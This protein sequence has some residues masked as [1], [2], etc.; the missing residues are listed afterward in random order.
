MWPF[1]LLRCFNLNS[2]CGKGIAFYY[3]MFTVADM[4]HSNPVLEV[5][6]IALKCECVAS[7]F[8]MLQRYKLSYQVVVRLF[9]SLIFTAYFPSNS[10]EFYC[11]VMGET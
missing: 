8:Y 4:S 2:T 9:I 10:K 7:K 11:K 6:Q 3:F 5:F 1:M